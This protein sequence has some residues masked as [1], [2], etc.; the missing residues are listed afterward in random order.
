[1]G[2]TAELQRDFIGLDLGPAL[3]A[4]GYKDVQL[5]ILDDQR[6]MLPAWPKTVSRTNNSNC[7]QIQNST[8]KVNVIGLKEI[9]M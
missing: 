8:E 6:L 3:H 9:I 4:A 7:I 2:F 1:M 5:M